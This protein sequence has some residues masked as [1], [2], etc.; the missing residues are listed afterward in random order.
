MKLKA[1]S[2]ISFFTVELLLLVL[3]VTLYITIMISSTYLL[4]HYSTRTCFNYGMTTHMFSILC[5]GETF[6]RRKYLILYMVWEFLL[7]FAYL[8]PIELYLFAWKVMYYLFFSLFINNDIHTKALVTRTVALI[9]DR[10][11]LFSKFIVYLKAR[12]LI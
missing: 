1:Y 11:D 3:I 5:L 12:L 9:F 6:V 10:L 4:F 2:F 7:L 8:Q